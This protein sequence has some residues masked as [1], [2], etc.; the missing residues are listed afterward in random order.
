MK[1]TTFVLAILVALVYLIS[2]AYAE[3]CNADQEIQD[4]YTALIQRGS[5]SP[6][7]CKE[8]ETHKDC[9]CKYIDINNPTLPPNYQF[10][11]NICGAC[12]IHFP[13]CPLE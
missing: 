6:I 3:R 4:C 10:V 13:I 5:P 7:C 11:P 9:L 12:G 2:N 1:N 8:L